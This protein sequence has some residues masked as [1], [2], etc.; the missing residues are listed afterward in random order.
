MSGKIEPGLPASSSGAGVVQAADSILGKVGEQAR[1][2]GIQAAALAGDVARD[3][4]TRATSLGGEVT[5][6]VAAA[7]RNGAAP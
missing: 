7:S 1:Q 3:A 5:D 4:Q 6:R 2:A